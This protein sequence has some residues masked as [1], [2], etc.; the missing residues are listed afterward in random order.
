ML[1]VDVLTDDGLQDAL[2]R[3][4]LEIGLLGSAVAVP[5]LM[6]RAPNVMLGTKVE[7]N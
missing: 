5:S 4:Q 3:A 1:L 2:K 7:T 6:S